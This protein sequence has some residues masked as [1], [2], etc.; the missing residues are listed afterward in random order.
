MCTTRLSKVL[1]S[2][3]TVLTVERETKGGKKKKK[4]WGKAKKNNV[5]WTGTGAISMNF[6]HIYTYVF[7]YMK[8]TNNVYMFIHFLKYKNL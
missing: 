2:K 3:A 4:E 6:V 1:I 8:Y 5:D 7:I